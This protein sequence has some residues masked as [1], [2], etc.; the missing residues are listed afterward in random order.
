MTH[1][2][3]QRG[4]NSYR[5]AV[6]YPDPVTGKEKLYTETVHDQEAAKLRKLE[7]EAEKIEGQFIPPKRM[8]ASEFFDEWLRVEGQK[9]SPKTYQGYES[10]IRVHL[11]PMFGQ[12]ELGKLQ[13]PFLIERAHATHFQGAARKD[14]TV[15]CLKTL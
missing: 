15:Q 13:N 6:W 3:Q 7:I 9:K 8:S 1:G 5:I 12:I 2:I 4:E 14:D 11:K 10:I